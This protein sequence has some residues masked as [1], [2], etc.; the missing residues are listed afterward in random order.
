[1]IQTS[2]LYRRGLKKPKLFNPRSAS[3]LGEN[4]SAVS[5]I[6]PSFNKDST[7]I[8][9]FHH[10]DVSGSLQNDGVSQILP[11]VE[12]MSPDELT[13]DDQIINE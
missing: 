7:L 1:M 11:E 10:Q 13:R 6:D 4:Q 5:L 2:L 9:T 8:T 12:V 3:Y